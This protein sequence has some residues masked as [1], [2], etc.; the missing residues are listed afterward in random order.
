MLDK[1][2]NHLFDNYGTISGYFLI[3]IILIICV[4]A[5]LGVNYLAKRNCSNYEKVT[6]HKTVFMD[7]DA[8]YIQRSDDSFVRY[9]NKFKNIEIMESK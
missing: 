8:C 3:Y 6:G 9:D 1:I 4:F 7:F 5:P 2:K